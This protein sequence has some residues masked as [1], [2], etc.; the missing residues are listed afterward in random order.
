MGLARPSG[1]MK[2]RNTV[3]QTAQF[4]QQR[5]RLLRVAG[6]VLGDPHEAEDIV[7]NAWLRMDGADSDIENLPGWLTTVTTRLCLDRLRARIPVPEANVDTVETAPDASEDIALAET[8]AVAL[9]ILLD[10]LTPTERVAFV[11]H[12]SF[13]FDFPT[14]AEILGRTPAAA[15]KLASRAR[16]KIAQP[17]TRS[18]NLTGQAD[19][20]VVDAFLIAARNGDFTR[21]LEL[22]APNV[23]VQGDPTA[24]TLGTPD[25]LEGAEQ[26]AQFFNGAAK[27]AFPVYIEDRPGAAWIHR[28]ELKVVFEFTIDRGRVQRIEFRAHPK[29]LDQV[30]KRQGQHR[31]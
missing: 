21:L 31:V 8:V 13:G 26:V 24:V 29:I 16:I 27:S 22:L 1:L 9:H 3:D 19:W 7:Q 17:A 6:R 28:G 30:Q 23:V 18:A 12:D 11:L 20:Q 2:T 25:R 15:R 14:I 4:E 10:R 5:P